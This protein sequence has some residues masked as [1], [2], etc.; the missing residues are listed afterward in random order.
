MSLQRAV[1]ALVV[2]VAGLLVLP[3]CSADPEAA[4]AADF[5]GVSATSNGKCKEPSACDKQI[6]TECGSLPKALAPGNKMQMR[7]G[8][9]KYAMVVGEITDFTPPTRFAHTFRFTQHDDP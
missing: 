4:P 3:G 8:S 6:A 2:A 7:T 9:G 1:V 5:C